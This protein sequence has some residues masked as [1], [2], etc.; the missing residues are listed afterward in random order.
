MIQSLQLLEKA[1][2]DRWVGIYYCYTMILDYNYEKVLF[3]H[4]VIPI[5]GEKGMV[6]FYRSLRFTVSKLDEFIY[7]VQFGEN[8]IHFH[9]PKLW[10]NKK[11]K[12]RGPNA[13]PGC[14]D[15]C[16]VWEGGLESILQFPEGLKISIEVGPM[17]NVG[18]RNRGKKV[19]QRTHECAAAFKR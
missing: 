6:L 3:D 13:T 7:A 17:E 16:F 2:T 12:L 9:T 11:F 19:G 14:G 5:N 15:F 4:V 8:K 1:Y 18:A 10:T